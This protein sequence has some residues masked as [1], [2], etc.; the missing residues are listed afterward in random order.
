MST[1]YQ[2][3]KKIKTDIKCSFSSTPNKALLREVATKNVSRICIQET[4]VYTGGEDFRKFKL[5]PVNPG[6]LTTFEDDTTSLCVVYKLRFKYFPS[7]IFQWLPCFIHIS[8]HIYKHVAHT[9]F[10][11]MNRNM[12]N[13]PLHVY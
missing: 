12:K 4:T 8:V 1:V 10:K 2:T 5:R 6:I 9:D 3:N 11:I 13:I 7:I